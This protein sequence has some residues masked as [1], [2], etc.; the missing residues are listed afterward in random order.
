MEKRNINLILKRAT[1]L[2]EV[3]HKLGVI[4]LNKS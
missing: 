2:D 1:P 3:R 4:P